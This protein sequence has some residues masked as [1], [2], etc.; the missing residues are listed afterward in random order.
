MKKIYLNYL[1]IA[2]GI[3]LIAINLYEKNW[4]VEKANVWRIIGA[5]CFIVLGT[6]NILKENKK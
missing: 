2:I 1:L 5:V 6:H 3:F 4:Q